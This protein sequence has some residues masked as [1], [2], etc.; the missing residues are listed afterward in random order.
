[1][2]LQR[3]L[4]AG[5]GNI[6]LCHF[7][8]VNFTYHSLERWLQLISDG[9]IAVN[10]I[11]GNVDQMLFVGDLL[12]YRAIGFTEPEVPGYFE[13]ILQTGEL[14]LVGKPAG[15]PVTRTG[16]IVRNTFVNLLRGHY[17][18]ELHPLH[19][20]DRETS[21]LLLCARG[22]DAC[23][24]YSNA[25]EPLI[26]GKYYLALVN[27][28]MPAGTICS[29]QPLA[30]RA[31]SPVRCRMWPDQAG[32]PCKTIFHVLATNGVFSLVLAELVTG[33]RHQIRAHLAHLGHPVVGDKIYSHGGHYF[34]KRTVGDLEESD[35]RALGA[36]NQ[37]LHAWAIWLNFPGRPGT[38]F[39]SR[40][41]SADFQR[42]LNLFPDWERLARERLAA[43]CAAPLPEHSC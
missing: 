28:R 29:E 15:I 4:R 26:V 34:L 14:L 19:R 33:R 10:G 25:P 11:V 42:Y 9:A 17:G 36:H 32:K 3:R 1:M 13:P 22:G 35:Y 21:G 30:P 37:T 16:L 43:M 6:S 18:E 2:L 20:L 40:L 24:K 12:A 27:G 38:F 7:L 5:E 8:A 31:E 41:Y 39:F 23:R